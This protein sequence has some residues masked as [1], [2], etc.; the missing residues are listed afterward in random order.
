MHRM[1][2]IALLRCMA[3]RSLRANRLNEFHER[4]FPHSHAAYISA[5]QRCYPALVYAGRLSL[6]SVLGLSPNA[7]RRP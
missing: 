4:T 6:A 3:Q 1:V 5:D 2:K 7:I